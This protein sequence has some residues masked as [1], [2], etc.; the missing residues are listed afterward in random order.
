MP[1]SR[2]SDE[3]AERR[4]AD[5]TAGGGE[6]LRFGAFELDLDNEELRRGGVLLHLAPQPFRLLAFLA[7]RAGELVPR[8]AIRDHLWGPGVHVE[9][10]Q[11]INALVREVR[12]VLGDDA[13]APRF[14]ATAP[15]RGYRF[16]APVERREA[17]VATV[18]EERVAGRAAPARAAGGRRRW[19]RTAVVVT[20]GLAATALAMLAIGRSDRSGA[21]RTGARPVTLAVLPF[22]DLGVGGSPHVATGLN[23]ELITLFGRRYRGDLRVIAP[24]SAL[25][26]RRSGGDPLAFAREVGAGY[27]LIGAI[28]RQGETLRISARLANA[29]TAAVLWASTYGRTSEDLLGLQEE[30]AARIA[31]ALALSLLGTSSGTETATRSPEAHREFLDGISL[32]RDEPGPGPATRLALAAFSRA[33][34]ADPGFAEAWAGRSAA[35]LRLGTATG[36]VEAESDAE[37]ALSLDEETARAH[38]LLGRIAFSVR[39]DLPRARASFERALEINPSFAEAHHSLAGWF[40]AH[41]RHEEALVSLARAV[42]LDPKAPSVVTGTCWFPYFARRWDE[43]LAGA[44]A[45]LT[46][47]PGY[48]YA[49]ECRTLVHL[50]RGHLTAA[51]EAAASEVAAGGD[52]L[53]ELFASGSPEADAVRA[54]ALRFARARDAGEPRAAIDAF[55]RWRLAVAGLIARHPQGIVSPEERA[56]A[57]AAL[58]ETETA[59]ALLERALD[60]RGG[61]RLPYLAVDPEFDPLRDEPRFQAVVATVFA[62]GG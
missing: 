34:Q 49:L 7:G 28:R 46:L 27:V 53:A 59:L 50:A 25:A 38:L 20:A 24:T 30:L 21:A 62:G 55:W 45:A 60:D 3:G 42:E 13:G 1:A 31:E 4:D 2:I 22:D 33:V 57:H 8:E 37:R 10:D 47:K 16:V 18:G 12:R 40:S 51:T 14:L 26:Y 19:R 35:G 15:R 58:G 5:T 17:Q 11:G 54:A 9:F 29:E 44:E 23:D 32:L 61:W 36:L 6:V 39:L 41:G 43:A 48:S 52:R 56:V